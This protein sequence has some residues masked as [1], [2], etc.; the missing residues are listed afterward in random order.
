L[1][2]IVFFSV[3]SILHFGDI[4]GSI[5]SDRDILPVFI[6]II[7][8][9][10]EEVKN[11]TFPLW[12]PYNFN[13]H[14]L[15][16][17]LLPVVLYPFSALYFFLPFDWA[18]NLNIEI[19]FAMS[20]WFT[21]LLL[22]GMKAS[23]GA[24]LVAGITFMLSGYMMSIPSFI[25]ILFSVTWVPLYLLVYF[26]A[27]KNNRLDYAV[28]SGVI[29][30]FMFLGGG[31]GVC[32]TTFGVA[33][34]ITIV[35]KLFLEEGTYFTIKRRLTTYG[36]FFL[37]LVGLSSVQLFPFYE[38]AKLSI[39]ETG[40][41][42][43]EATIWSLHPKDL[44]EFFVP[45]LYGIPL[46]QKDYWNY[47]SWLY[48]AY[49][50][51]LPFILSIFFFKKL[52]RRAFGF[53][54]LILISV[55]IALGKHTPVHFF[56]FEYLPFFDKFRFPTKFILI[57]VLILSFAA[58]LGYDLFKQE[59]QSNPQK[60][61]NTVKWILVLGF[62]SI[63]WFGLLSLSTE[64][65]LL[66]VNNPNFTLAEINQ[67]NLKRLLAFTS[68]YCLCLFLYSKPTFQNFFI[69]FILLSLFIL[70]LFF[71]NANQIK[72]VKWERINQDEATEKFLNA[73]DSLFRVFTTIET[74]NLLRLRNSKWGSLN[75]VKEKLKT[76]LIGSKRIFLITGVV[77]TKLSR[78][79]KVHKL[80]ITSPTVDSTNLLTLMNAKYVLSIPKIMS[81]DFKLVHEIKPLLA[82]PIRGGNYDPLEKLRVKKNGTVLPLIRKR[83]DPYESLKIYENKNVLPRAFLVPTCKI[84]KNEGE[85]K[86]LLEDKRFDPSKFILVD[87]NPETFE[88]SGQV[89]LA[90]KDKGMVKINSYKSNEVNITVETAH[91]QFLFMSDTFYP[92][93][94]SYVDDKEVEI[95]RAN[96]KF[97]AI[98]VEPGIH[99]VRFEYDPLSFK[100][101]LAITLLTFL[102]CLVIICKVRIGRSNPI[103]KDSKV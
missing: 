54:F 31:L 42:Y 19:H 86:S 96:Y 53:L 2:P 14:P 45:D 13:G 47:Q 51:S 62:L 83:Y 80:L 36:I 94:K 79:D 100:F 20:G 93:W 89:A 90:D 88:C 60:N 16:A 102:I 11:L 67:F 25:S 28:Y 10:V 73:D 59:L 61:I 39:R 64:P 56:L 21:Y 99:Q 58:G 50:G 72:S 12:N 30:T 26:A 78:G 8:F 63:L 77:I 43:S 7:Q 34:L 9:W 66:Q 81:P 84:A 101:G 22:R 49:M 3:L 92:G 71:A 65:F 69:L 5:F 97:R 6:P 37:V 48:S 33:L 103:L 38:L 85:Y 55:V 17:T 18:F 91:R 44:V 46:N 29:G 23:H 4:R 57:G 98:P 70:D 76:G 74:D 15:F 75:E 40:M 35:P 68:C 52:D 27:I 32:Y 95:I 82:G 24:S 41:A 1:W 87:K